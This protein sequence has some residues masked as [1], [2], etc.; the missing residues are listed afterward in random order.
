MNNVTITLDRHNASVEQA[1]DFV[2]N[3]LEELG[4]PM[5]VGSGITVDARNVR[6]MK[7]EFTDN[8]MRL[9][10]G[11]MRAES[12][13]VTGATADTVREFNF[14]ASV[15]GAQQK[16]LINGSPAVPP[17]PHRTVET[18]VLADNI[19]SQL[20]TRRGTTPIPVAFCEEMLR[21]G[22]VVPEPSPLAAWAK[23]VES[24]IF[25]DTHSTSELEMAERAVGPVL[26]RYFGETIE[27]NGA[28]L[29]G[30]TVRI[31]GEDHRI[32]GQPCPNCITSPECRGRYFRSNY[33]PSCGWFAVP[34]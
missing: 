1:E 6:V 3:A 18:A 28:W 25:A 2:S 10:M 7:P 26:I 29:D 31:K 13:D 20:E 8:F 14:A 27:V 24:R 21:H 17:A 32:T 9:S 19:A 5:F 33:C 34:F 16:L 12:M 11:L 4:A 22:V 30:E 23:E 15:W